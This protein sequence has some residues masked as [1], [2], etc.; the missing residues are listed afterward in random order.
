MAS[1]NA[2]SRTATVASPEQPTVGIARTVDDSGARYAP[3]RFPRDGS[4]ATVLLIVGN[5]LFAANCG[6]SAG[7]Q[8]K[9]MSRFSP[10][11]E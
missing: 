4:T 5:K 2:A 6:D 10:R 7:E 8:R 11:Y 3:A 9:L 1:R